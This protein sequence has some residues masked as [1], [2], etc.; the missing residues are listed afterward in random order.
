MVSCASL[1][2]PSQE[3]AEALIAKKD[4]EIDSISEVLKQ[5]LPGL[6]EDISKNIVILGN[7]K[8][9]T[10]IINA[11]G[12]PMTSL[13]NFENAYSLIQAKISFDSVFLI[14]VHQ[15]QTL[16]TKEF[17][18]KLINFEDAKKY[19]S[20]SVRI[21][22]EVVNYFKSKGSRVIVLGI[23]FG[24]FVVEDLLA[25][26]PSN[27]DKYIIVVGRLD[28]P[29]KV[30]QEFAKGNYVGFK[31][32]H[33]EPEIVKFTAE[34]AGM[35]GGNTIGDKNTSILA[36]G[37]GYKR[38]TQL[39]REKDLSKVVYF[40]GYKDDQVGRLSNEEIKFLKSKNVPFLHYDKD[41][42]GTID[43]FLVNDFK[44]IVYEI[45]N[46]RNN[47]LPLVNFLK[48][49]YAKEEMPKNSDYAIKEIEFDSNPQTKEYILLAISGMQECG[50]GGCNMYIIN[51]LGTALC[52]TT[53]VN[54]PIYIEAGKKYPDIVVWSD[55][56]YRKLV[57]D[58]EQYS[59]NASVAEGVEESE[60]NTAGKYRL[61]FSQ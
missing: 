9:N 43:E 55:G 11:Q 16:R 1:F 34:E 57:F 46:D 14:N 45:E 32:K 42:G 20:E 21:L 47:N 7:P 8:A 33:G 28:M 36:A 5:Q 25:N 4:L 54:T 19:D 3:E 44:K 26:Y 22:A 51:E 24:A 30:W 18:S 59:P 12:G 17:E 60:I 53:V 6:P 27:A 49:N 37:L 40:Y 2:G 23:S 38:F 61:L 56:K 58:G 31:Y 52:K 48:K 41:H 15:Y 35:G 39:L 29:D 13:H 10:V 50:S